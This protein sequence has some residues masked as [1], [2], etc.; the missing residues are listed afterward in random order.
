[1]SC[2]HFRKVVHTVMLTIILWRT[3]CHVT[4][5]WAHPKSVL[6]TD[7][8]IFHFWKFVRTVTLTIIL[9][10]T[11]CHMT[12]YWAHPKSVLAPVLDSYGVGGHFFRCPLV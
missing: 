11:E 12:W 6:A 5:C 9:W 1:M 7:L 4:W 10:R 2:F 8:L 3:K